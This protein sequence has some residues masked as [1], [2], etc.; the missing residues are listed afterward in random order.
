MGSQCRRRANGPLGLEAAIGLCEDADF[1]AGYGGASSRRGAFHE[2]ADNPPIAS[3]SRPRNR[4]TSH[5]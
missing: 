5:T 1:P 3:I 4:L 2:T